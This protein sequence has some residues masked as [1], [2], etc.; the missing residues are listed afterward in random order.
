MEEILCIDIQT[1]SLP[2]SVS[3][4]VLYVTSP[5]NL[6]TIAQPGEDGKC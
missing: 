5:A 4:E 2:V 1:L 6:P 3:C